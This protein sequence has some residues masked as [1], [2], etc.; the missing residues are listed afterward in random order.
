MHPLM[1][2]N[3]VPQKRD[4]SKAFSLPFPLETCEPEQKGVG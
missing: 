3:I 4:Q 1:R 2:H